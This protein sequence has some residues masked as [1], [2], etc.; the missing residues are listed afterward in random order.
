M[1]TASIITKNKTNYVSKKQ[2][3]TGGVKKY[4]SVGLYVEML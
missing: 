4:L 1:G 2:E 3:N